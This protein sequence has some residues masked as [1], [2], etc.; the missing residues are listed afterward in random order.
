MH[1]GAGLLPV[2][3]I[4]FDAP[5][6]RGEECRLALHLSNVEFED[7]RVKGSEWLALKPTLPFQAMP[8]LEL[9]GKPPLA[10]SNAIL[11][12]IGRRWGLHPKDDFEAARHEA[13]LEHCEDLR[14]EIGPTTSIKD[15]AA[16]KAAREEIAK[17]LPVWC[18]GIEHQLGSGPFFAGAQLHVVDIKLFVMARWLLSGRLDH[19]P[20][21]IVA[22]YPRFV[23]LHDA[24]RDHAGVK[25]WYAR[26]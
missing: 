1:P 13:I 4:Y 3:L 11:V 25:A 6:S 17:D 19:I 21:S 15:D 22:A 8:V 26:A 16:R 5:V 14:H 23:R 20:P 18:A 10:Q 9:E 12:Y 7:V 2:K 24:V